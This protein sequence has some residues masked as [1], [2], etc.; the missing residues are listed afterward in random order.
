MGFFL[1]IDGGGSK[2]VC[3]VGDE[4]KVL[5]TGTGGA[6]NVV[7]VGEQATRTA[8]AEALGKACAEA[9]VAPPQILRTCI[10]AAGGARP[11]VET[12]VQGILA[13]LVSGEIEVVGDMEIA[14][15]A[16]FGVWPGIVVIAGTGSI[17]YGRN[18]IGKTARAGGWGH[19]ISDEGSGHWIGRRAIGAALLAF[20][21]GQ[22]PPL[23]ETLM[24][25]WNL[26]SCAGLVL[27]ANAFPP[28]D[29]ASLFPV[30]MS[31]SDAD[32]PIARRV[33]T[34]AGF[35]LASLAKIVVSR[36]FVNEP[37]RVAMAGGV[38]RNSALVREFLYNQLRSEFPEIT[39]EQDI[40]DPVMGAL[41]RAR[42]GANAVI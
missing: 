13:E 41:E 3:V 9:K 26:N 37:T 18:A 22:D 38:L 30:I 29:F 11:E 33:L 14:L 23:L 20:D 6:S 15:E 5:G 8:I 7:R 19:A 27:A 39:I 28:P 31:A 16:A 17:V 12:V 2:T 1:G 21:Q 10:G 25:A 35:R 24:R 32:D 40:V 42:R 34:Q 4:S 36:I